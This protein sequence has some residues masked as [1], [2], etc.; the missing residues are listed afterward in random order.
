M[1]RHALALLDRPARSGWRDDY[2]T[3]LRDAAGLL[4]LAVESGSEAV[5]RTALAARIAS[6]PA[7]SALSPQEAVWSLRAAQALRHDPPGLSLDGSP[8]SGTL[9][10]LRGAGDA[11]QRITNTGTRETTLTLTAF[12]VP[13]EP[14]PAGGEGYRIS[15]SYFHM[16]G[17]PADPSV[18]RIG[19]RLVTVLEITAFE[20]S[21]AR[22]M[23]DDPL[24]AGF[25]IDNPN[26]IRAGDIAALSWLQVTEWAEMTEVRQERFLAAMDWSGRDRLRLA[27]IARAVSPGTF[28]HPAAQV[29]DMYR[30]TRRARTAPGRV[31]I[32]E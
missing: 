32:S 9:A 24:P 27:Y 10:R 6:R 30:P 16:D 12:G 25:E 4:T 2:G 21:Q 28:H 11:A 29:E 18:I 8:V 19:D 17:T 3:A 5:D 7:A 22:L 26:L 20:E 23:V 31:T 1:F 15:R 14:E 13:Q